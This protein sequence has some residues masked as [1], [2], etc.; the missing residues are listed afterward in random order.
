MKILLIGDIILDKNIY[1]LS[2]RKCPENENLPVCK[3]KKNEY[4]IGGCGNI[5]INLNNLNHDI[6]LFSYVGNDK[7][8]NIIYKKLDENG[9]KK[10]YIISLDR[11]TITKNRIFLDNKLIC[12]YDNESDIKVEF[13][14]FEDKLKNIFDKINLD[15]IIL[16]DYAKGTLS[17]E[18]SKFVIDNAN[19]KKI[20]I[21]I[22][23]K[24][25]NIN[26]YKN[27]TIIKANID[28]IKSIYFKLIKKEIEINYDNISNYS[29]KICNEYNFK[30]LITSLADK[31]IF[32]YDN[33]NK[34][35]KLFNQKYIDKNEVV[36][37]TGAGDLVLSILSH[38]YPNVYKG[39]LVANK[40]AQNSVKYI[41][42]QYISKE[43]IKEFEI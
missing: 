18:L 25:K 10:K 38:F 1:T 5:A 32:L 9:I 37:V 17:N 19:K 31:G 36:D 3:V 6:F 20:P 41:G 24:P 11:P 40:I 23:P 34:S 43:K 33:I 2:N 27:S 26:N 29:E 21:I 16:S 12:R 14:F 42:V 28:E 15:M 22:D 39:C 8:K 13:K 30:Y 4:L 35:K 7:N